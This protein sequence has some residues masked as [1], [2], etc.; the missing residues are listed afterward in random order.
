VANQ[1]GWFKRLFLAKLRPKR[2]TT[3]KNVDEQCRAQKISQTDK[4]LSFVKLTF[5][6]PLAALAD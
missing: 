3:A 1:N 6:F 2:F 4:K 5:V